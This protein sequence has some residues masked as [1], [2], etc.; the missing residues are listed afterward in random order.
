[1]GFTNCKSATAFFDALNVAMGP[2]LGTEF[3][4]GCPDTLFA[5]HNERVWATRYEVVENL[6]RIGVW[7]CRLVRDCSKDQ[8][9]AEGG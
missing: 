3:K 6:V 4:L 2:S 7:S 1:M 5:H 9:C 8:C